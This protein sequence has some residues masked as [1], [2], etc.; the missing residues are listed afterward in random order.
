[1]VSHP[2]QE[3]GY[4]ES[5]LFIRRIL[6][7][8]V[9]GGVEGI[10]T[11]SATVSLRCP[12]TLRRIARIPGRGMT[13]MPHARCFDVEALVSTRQP[14]KCPLC[15][16]PLPRGMTDIIVDGFFSELLRDR[17]SDE[18]GVGQ[19]VVFRNEGGFTVENE[20]DPKTHYK[21]ENIPHSVIE[22]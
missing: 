8:E 11:E 6:F 17:I 14:W 18:S 7:E 21:I 22:L 1:M 13:C 16:Q 9:G 10:Q 12:L 4:C 15:S 5:L 20:R 2:Y 3:S 19:C